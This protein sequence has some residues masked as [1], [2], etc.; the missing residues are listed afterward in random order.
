[1]S[2]WRGEHVGDALLRQPLRMRVFPAFSPATLAETQ[3]ARWWIDGGDPR[4]SDACVP[5][6]AW[7]SDRWAESLG[8]PNPDPVSDR[9]LGAISPE[10][11]HQTREPIWNWYHKIYQQ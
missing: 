6:P 9:R 3:T 11:G 2:D 8:F 1:M 4:S 10:Q 5:R 7:P